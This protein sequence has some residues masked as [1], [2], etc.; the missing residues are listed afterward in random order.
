MKNPQFYKKAGNHVLAFAVCALPLVAFAQVGIKN[1][2]TGINSI[3]DIIAAV[4]KVVR[5]VAIPFVVLA[6]IYSGFLF[7][8]AQGRPDKLTKARGVL[9]WTLIGALIVLSSELIAGVLKNAFLTN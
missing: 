7:V 4:I 2:A 5:L 9:M 1:P 3:S 8:T 6:I